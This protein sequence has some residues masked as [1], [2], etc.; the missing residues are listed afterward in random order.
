MA[1]VDSG[2]SQRA[3]LHR[4]SAFGHHL[5][6]QQ[7]QRPVEPQPS[8]AFARVFR[9]VNVHHLTMPFNLPATL[10]RLLPG[11]E[12][13]V[14]SGESSNTSSVGRRSL[15]QPRLPVEDYGDGRGGG[16]AGGGNLQKS[17]S[18]GGDI[19]AG[20]NASDER[21]AEFGA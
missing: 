14:L 16:V 10:H 2:V 8:V 21:W 11:L 20:P 15:L 1:D 3:K 12:H 18:V 19:V 6:I 7:H 5:P 13:L 9:P 4:L 17:L